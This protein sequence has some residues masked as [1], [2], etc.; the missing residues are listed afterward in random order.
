MSNGT[1]IPNFFTYFMKTVPLVYKNMKTMLLSLKRSTSQNDRL[2]YKK[3]K[4]IFYILSSK[5][6][7]R[8]TKFE[9]L[10]KI[11]SIRE[12]ALITG[13]KPNFSDRSGTSSKK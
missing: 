4:S 8:R 1:H 10:Q 12:Q 13:S 9:Y 6:I 11:F 3:I 5:K 2:R 7:D